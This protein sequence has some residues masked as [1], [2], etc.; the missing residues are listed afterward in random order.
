M[1]S[2]ENIKEI[3]KFISRTRCLYSDYTTTIDKFKEEN[4]DL[5]MNYELEDLSDDAGY[6]LFRIFH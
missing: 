5:L 3:E 1:A 6:K 4:G 2:N